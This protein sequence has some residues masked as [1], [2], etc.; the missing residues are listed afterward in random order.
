M[1]VEDHIYQWPRYVDPIDKELHQGISHVELEVV[2]CIPCLTGLLHKSLGWFKG[3]ITGK[4][5]ISWEILWFPVDF[6]L[7][8]AIE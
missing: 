6:L 8:Q 3:K 4:S 2:L 7:S 5:H 1:H